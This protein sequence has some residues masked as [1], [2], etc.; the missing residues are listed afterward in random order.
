M[1][2]RPVNSPTRVAIPSCDTLVAISDEP[3]RRTVF[4]KNSDRPVFEAQPMFAVGARRTGR[5]TLRCQYLEVEQVPETLAVLGSRPWWLWGFEHGVNEAG[6]VI[7]NEAVYTLDPVQEVG[8]LGMDL[9]RL[10]LERSASAYEAVKTIT[11]LIG[12]YGQGGRAIL[13]CDRRYHNSFLIGDP[14]HSWL[15]ET[16]DRHWAA[17]ELTGSSAIS[18]LLTITDDWDVASAGI[19]RYAS[20]LGGRWTGREDSRLNFRE[21]FEDQALRH[22]AE[23]RYQAGCEFL[24]A[25]ARCSREDMVRHLRSH[26]GDNTTHASEA[27]DS[28]S[29]ALTVCL[30]EGDWATCTAAS[31]VVELVEGDDT[32]IVAWCAM[33]NPCY[34]P[35]LPIKVGGGALPRDFEEHDEGKGSLWWTMRRLGQAIERDP[36]RLSA[37]IRSEWMELEH[38]ITQSMRESADAWTLNLPKWVSAVRARSEK[39]VRDAAQLR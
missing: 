8:L 39:I 24:G 11:D 17:R 23:R 12:R 14:G 20:R 18:N 25:H 29:P 21:A 5:R 3:I 22:F 26:V 9:V 33:G 38:A 19:E 1:W 27:G 4:G 15:L 31:M 34:A 37:A 28:D 32:E 30:H 7:G 10:A 2:S 13:D 35:Y 36:W 6:V 16:S